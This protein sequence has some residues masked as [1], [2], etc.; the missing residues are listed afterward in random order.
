[1][2][3]FRSIIM[4][5]VKLPEISK[6]SRAHH[7]SL[8]KL[9]KA[10]P[11]PSSICLL[12]WAARC[13][14]LMLVS[15]ILAIILIQTFRSSHLDQYEHELSCQCLAQILVN[16]FSMFPK[17]IRQLAGFQNYR[18]FCAIEGEFHGLSYYEGWISSPQI[19]VR[20]QDIWSQDSATTKLRLQSF[21]ISSQSL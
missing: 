6:S 5:V 18:V 14:P 10:F 17:R 9:L 12:Q 7:I 13:S 8:I 2:K 11:K 19:N 1:M 4:E 16:Y 15:N 20:C 3:F 21:P